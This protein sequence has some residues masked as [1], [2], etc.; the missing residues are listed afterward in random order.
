MDQFSIAVGSSA[1]EFEDVV[2]NWENKYGQLN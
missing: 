1:Y 2:D